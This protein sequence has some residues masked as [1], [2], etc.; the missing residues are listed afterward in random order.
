MLVQQA[1]LSE[2]RNG[3]P[4]LQTPGNT[5]VQDAVDIFQGVLMDVS[6]RIRM[7][8]QNGS[9]SLNYRRSIVKSPDDFKFI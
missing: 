8:T 3:I 1:M 7:E 5:I 2:M 9:T 6:H 4:I